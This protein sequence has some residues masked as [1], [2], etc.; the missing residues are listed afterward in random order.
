M[1][2]EEQVS[3]ANF[4]KNDDTASAV[5]AVAGIVALIAK[6]C[7]ELRNTHSH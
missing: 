1:S 7:T 6:V 5:H 4:D 2:A 3:L